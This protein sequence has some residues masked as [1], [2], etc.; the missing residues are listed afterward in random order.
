QSAR[1]LEVRRRDLRVGRDAEG[2]ETF[3]LALTGANDP[4]PYRRGRLP[5]LAAEDL[6]LLQPVDL[7][8]EVDAVD[9]RTGQPIRVRGEPAGQAFALTD[10]VARVPARTGVRRGDEL[11]P[12]GVRHAPPA[13]NDRDRSLLERA[14]QR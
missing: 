12:A 14:A 1:L 5:R 11:E 7:D 4:L 8:L 10:G 2:S 13:A 3:L 6:G 9:H